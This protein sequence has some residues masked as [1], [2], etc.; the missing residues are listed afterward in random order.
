MVQEKE[1]I[2]KVN[3]LREVGDFKD[4]KM[5]KQGNQM[6]EL[7]VTKPSNNEMSA[8]QEADKNISKEVSEILNAKEHKVIKL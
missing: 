8:N 4:I 6:K 2:K 5:P 7:E 1:I 3:D